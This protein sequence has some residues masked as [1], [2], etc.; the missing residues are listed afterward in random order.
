[1][2]RLG[3]N[4][5]RVSPISVKP[6]LRTVPLLL[7]SKS[8]SVSWVES[9]RLLRLDTEEFRG[10]VSS[11]L[12]G[13]GLALE[14]IIGSRPSR[15]PTVLGTHLSSKTG[16]VQSWAPGLRPVLHRGEF[17]PNYPR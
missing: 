10:A 17:V 1:V 14:L 13:E 2:A 5:S 15:R 6:G 12:G 3:R 11:V 16:S 8:D 9:G 7:A 4:L